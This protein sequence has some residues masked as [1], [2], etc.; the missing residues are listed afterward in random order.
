VEE[1]VLAPDPVKGPAK[2]LKV[3]LAQA[4]TVPGRGGRM[5]GRSVAFNGEHHLAR[6]RRMLGGEIDP[7]NRG[8]VLGDQRY[9][10]RPQVCLDV[11]LERIE[12]GLGLRHV[13]EISPAGLGVGQDQ[14]GNRLGLPRAGR[15][16]D[17]A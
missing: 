5:V 10:G 1:P 15:P 11:T 17:A 13:A 7:V 3:L 4:V 12:A 16:V 6:P 9:P 14:I 2:P 8:S